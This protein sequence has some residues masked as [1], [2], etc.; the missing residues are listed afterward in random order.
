MTVLPAGAISI[1][2]GG[3]VLAAETVA[4]RLGLEPQALQAELHRGQV[5]CLVETG[6]NEDK[7]RTRVTVRYH[8]RSFTWVIEPDGKERTMTWST[9]ALPSPFA[10]RRSLS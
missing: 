9:S 5:C 4:P 3:N 10:S 6:I 7:S 1:T 8:A 2:D